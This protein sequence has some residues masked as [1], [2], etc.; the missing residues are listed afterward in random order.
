MASIPPPSYGGGLGIHEIKSGLTPAD[1]LTLVARTE[2]RNRDGVK[3]TVLPPQPDAD[4][5]MVWWHQAGDQ[6]ATKYSVGILHHA[7]I[8]G[9]YSRKRPCHRILVFP[10]DCIDHNG[11][12]PLFVGAGD[13]QPRR[14]A[15]EERL[16]WRVTAVSQNTRSLCVTDDSFW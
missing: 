3:V 9:T 1:P 11:T 8:L 16:R 15:P 14:A 10:L 5:P 7:N 13:P 4:W 12:A 2:L 6:F